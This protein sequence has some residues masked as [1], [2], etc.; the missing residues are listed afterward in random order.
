[1]KETRFAFA[2]AY[3]RTLENKM[4]SESDIDSMLNM[5]NVNEAVRFL[6]DKNY[7]GADRQGSVNVSEIDEM[8]RSELENAWAEITE[9]CPKG[10][11][12]NVLLYKND[13]QNLKTIMKAVFSKKEWKHLMLY[14]VTVDVDLMHKA[15]SENDI[16]A[17]PEFMQSAASEAYEILAHYNDG[18]AAD[19]AID[20]H[21]F[22]A[23]EAEA[24]SKKNDF[25]IG[26]IQLWAKLNNMKL[27]LRAAKQ[28]KNKEFV[29]KSFLPSDDLYVDSLA[30]AASQDVSAVVGVFSQDGYEFGAE[31]A[32]RSESDF[33]KWADNQLMDYVKTAQYKCFGFEPLMAF[34]YGKQAEIQ[35]V[36]IVLYGLLNNIPK[37]ILKERLREMY[38]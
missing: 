11:P 7:G 37:H 2:V 1:M 35:T 13:F 4:L 30:E 38:V 10:A 31:A 8:L 24:Q 20:K 34:L 23:M 16:E 36:R 9:V 29:Q 14:P 12:I 17:L 5:G 15:V 22:A 28:K 19:I 27:A 32:N 18:Q 21:A 25:L 3:M 33:E 26:W 6:Q